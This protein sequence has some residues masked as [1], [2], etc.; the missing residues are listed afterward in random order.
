MKIAKA[1]GDSCD[2][3]MCTC[4]NRQHHRT[5]TLGPIVIIRSSGIDSQNIVEILEFDSELSTCETIYIAQ[6]LF[7]GGSEVWDTVSEIDSVS[8]TSSRENDEQ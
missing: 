1:N 6:E 2:C 3:M 5:A 7:N 8:D 4:L